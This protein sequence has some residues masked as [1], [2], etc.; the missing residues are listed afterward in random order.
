MATP[1]QLTLDF[2]FAITPQNESGLA[3]STVP[4]A[5]AYDKV[6]DE[7][8][9]AAL[10]HRPLAA[11]ESLASADLSDVGTHV[12]TENAYARIASDPNGFRLVPGTDSCG[13][14][15]PIAYQLKVSAK[16]RQ[17]YLRVE[18]GRGLQ[19]TIPKRYPKRTIP[20]LVES[21]R[22][23]ITEA[24]IDLDEKNLPLYRQWP[25]AQLD[26]VACDSVVDIYYRKNTDSFTGSWLWHTD[27]QLYLDVDIHNKPLVASCIADALKPRAKALLGPWLQGC[28]TASGLRYKKMSIRG[29]KTVWGS[30][31]ST[32]TLSLNFKLLFLRR[33]L[34]DYVLLHELA[35]TR[36][37]DHSPAF[38]HFLDQLKPNAAI[39]DR[40]LN[41]A[42][43]LVPPWLE[44]AGAC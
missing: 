6:Q 13:R 41:E 8:H 18:P 43:T 42:G 30:Y 16:A 19:V 10:A 25:P 29:Q 20:A 22:A 36:H 17:V 28:A 12:T 14:P 33:E 7:V 24:L 4:P 9:E 40:E 3:G 32:G 2:D 37:L 35:H 15:E 26:L 34:V 39:Y 5:Q 44:L 23:W 11:S 38:W 27:K 21:Q 31:S 1:H